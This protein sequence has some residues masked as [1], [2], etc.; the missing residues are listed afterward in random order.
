[1]GMDV[2]VDF[3]LIEM[4]ARATMAQLLPATGTRGTGQVLVD[5]TAGGDDIVIPKN[6]Y[7]MPVVGSDAGAGELREDLLFKTKPNPATVSSTGQ[8]GAWTVPAGQTLPV[9]IW[10]NVGGVRHNLPAGTLFQWEPAVDGLGPTVAL[11]ADITDGADKDTEPRLQRVAYYEELDS[12][13][14]ARDLQSGRLSQLPALMVTWDSSAP[15]E[16]RTASTNQGST[17]AKAG[18]RFFTE[19]FKLF[20]IVG[21]F[22]GDGKRRRSGLRL[23]QAVT[24]LLTDQ[25]Q[26][27]DFEF[28]SSLGSLEVIGRTRYSRG[29]GHYVYALTMR[30]TTAISM[31]DNR[32]YTPWLKTHTTATLPGRTAPEPTTPI[33]MVDAIDPMPPGT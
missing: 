32:S 24:R 16:G 10:S 15:A 22:K 2:P 29:P 30:L 26:N 13:N 4:L 25:Q 7:L 31:V 21:E 17:R 3:D 8:G 19:T 9:A 33:T 11:V 5:N 1:M 18:T 12:A 6:L 28:M 27:A 23:L 20:I 14:I